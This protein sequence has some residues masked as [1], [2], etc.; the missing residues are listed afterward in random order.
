RLSLPALAYAVSYP[1]AIVGIIASLLFLKS[2]FRIDPAKEAQEFATQHR[3]AI[4][5]LE[6]RTMVVTNPNLDG[7][8][9]DEIPGKIEA[10]VTVSRV[11]HN[12]E[13]VVATDATVFHQ[14]DRLAVIG[15]HAGL[16]QFERVI[17][18][19]SEED[20]LLEESNIT[21]RRVV[22]TDCKLLGKT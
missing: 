11:R 19:R 2:I 17:G 12:E 14:N 3:V 10:Q 20:L 8:R 6:R 16:D 4:E 13:T 1:T 22:V 7:L 15:T 9:I 18:Q 5:P 21:F